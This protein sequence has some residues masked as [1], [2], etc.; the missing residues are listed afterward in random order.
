[1]SKTKNRIEIILQIISAFLVAIII[2][3]CFQTNQVNLSDV[4]SPKKAY[5]NIADYQKDRWCTIRKEVFG[6][7]STNM[8]DRDIA[9]NEVIAENKYFNWADTSSLDITP[10]N[11]TTQSIDGTEVNWSNFKDEATSITDLDIESYDYSDSYENAVTGENVQVNNNMTYYVANVKTAEEFRWILFQASKLNTYS[12]KINIEKDI[13]LNGGNSKIWKSISLSGNRYVYI[14]GN[15]H[16]IYNFR[17]A[18]RDYT[19]GKGLLGVI[20]T[21]LIIKNLNFESALNITTSVNSAILIGEIDDTISKGVYLDNIKFDKIFLQ[22]SSTNAGALIGRTNG[23]KNKSVF[24]KNCSERN[25]YVCGTEHIGGLTGC[26]LNT[27]TYAVKYNAA[28][29]N[30]PE[31]F[32]GSAIYPEMIDSCYAVDSEVFSTG[33]D[34][35][36]FISCGGKIIVRNCFTNNTIYANIYTGVFIGREVSAQCG[37]VGLYD[38]SGNTSINSYFENCYTSGIIEGANGIGG[39]IGYLNPT[40]RTKSAVFKNCYSTSMVGM[41][42]AGNNVGGFIGYD[43]TPSTSDIA[44]KIDGEIKNFKGVVIINSYAAGEVGDIVTNT[45]NTENNKSTIGGFIGSYTNNP[46]N[47][48]N[49]YYDKQTTGMRERGIGYIP[50]NSTGQHPGLTGTYTVGSNLEGGTPGLTGKTGNIVDL[51]DSSVWST[52]DGIYPQ[53][54]V[55]EN[56]SNWSSEEMELVKCYSQA[57][58]STVFLEHWDHIMTS[59]NQTYNIQ[60]DELFTPTAKAE[61]NNY[62]YDT[63]RD[64]TLK[65]EFSSNENSEHTYNNI[66]W[67]VDNEMNQSRNFVEDFSIDYDN[68]TVTGE[69]QYNADVL[70]ILNPGKDTDNINPELLELMQSL[71]ETK[72]IYKCYEFAPGKSWIKVEVKSNDGNIT[73]M[74][75]LR[76]LPMAYLDAGNYAE[77]SIDADGNNHIVYKSSDGTEY[78]YNGENYKH[79]IDTL[80]TNTSRENLGNGT[81]YQSQEVSKSNSTKFAMWGRYPANE[82]KLDNTSRFDGLYNQ[83]MI[84]NATEGMT[85]VEVYKLDVEYIEKRSESGQVTQIP[86]IN[87][88]NA[89][90]ITEENLDNEKWTGMVNFGLD[91]AGWYELRYYWRLNDGR[92][93]SDSKIVVIK[94]STYTANIK[95]QILNKDVQTDPEIMPDI[96]D[97]TNNPENLV[98]DGEAVDTSIDQNETIIRTKEISGFA[99]DEVLMGWK[100]DGNYK[101]VDVKI[102]VSQ[103]GTNWIPLVLQLENPENPYDFINAKYT[104]YYQ[105]YKMIQNP[106]TKEYYLV[107]TD[108]PKEISTTIT[109]MQLGDNPDYAKYI[110]LS[111][112]IKEDDDSIRSVNSDVRVSATF[113]PMDTHVK[114]E[115]FV[116]KENVFSGDEVT[117]TVIM[118]P[119]YYKDAFDINAE[120]IIPL[121]TEY[122]P[123][124][125]EIGEYIENTNTYIPDDENTSQNFENNTLTWHYDKMEY[126]KKYYAKFK[127]KVTGVVDKDKEDFIK[128]DNV[129]N[130]TYRKSEFGKP[131]NGE[132]SEAATFIII[133]E[134]RVYLIIEKNVTTANAPI[135]KFKMNAQIEK[136]GDDLQ[137]YKWYV[138][139]EKENENISDVEITQNQIAMLVGRTEGE[140][141]LD[142]ASFKIK[143]DLTNMPANYYFSSI[144][145]SGEGILE[146]GK[147]QKVIVSNYYKAPTEQINVFIEKKDL[148]SQEYVSLAQMKLQKQSDNEEYV[149]YLIWQTTQSHKTVPLETGKY[150]IIEEVAPTDYQL[151]ETP[152]EFEIVKNESGNLIVKDAEGSILEDKRITFYNERI[153]YNYTVEYYYDNIKDEDKTET[154]RGIH[155]SSIDAYTDKVIPG[156]ELDKTESFPLTVTDNESKNVIKVFYKKRNDLSY[157]VRYREEG[158]EDT[159]ADLATALTIGEQTFGDRVTVNAIAIDGYEKVE[160]TSAE[161]EITAGTNEYIFYYRKRNDLSYTVRYREEGAEDTE[162]DLAT[163]LTVGEQTFGDKVTVNAIAIDG[164]EKVDPTSADIEITTGTN[165]HI[166]YYTKRN[167]LSYTVNY[168]DKIT[169]E[170]IHDSKVQDRQ[171]YNDEIISEDEKIEIDGYVFDSS[172]KEKIQIGIEDNIINLYYRKRNDLSYK[173]NY[174]ESGTGKTLHNAKIQNDQEFKKVINANDEIIEIYGYNFDR[175]DKESI[176]I[177]TGEN[178]INLYYSKKDAKVIVHHYAENSITK[179]SEDVEINN[180]MFDKY[181]TQAATDIDNKYELVEVPS[182]AKGEMN[183]EKIEVIYYYKV[184]T[185]TVKIKYIDLDNNNEIAN[186][187]TISGKVDTNYETTSKEIDNYQLVKDSKNTTGKYTVEPI[188]VIYYYLPK[189]KV[190]V[191]YIDKNYNNILETVTINGLLGDEYTTIAKNIERYCLIELPEKTEGTMTR[192]D[193]IVNYY[194]VHVSAGVIEKHIDIATGEILESTVHEGNEGDSY[195][196]GSKQFEGYILDENS[197][198]DNNKGKMKQDVIEVIYYYK[199]PT[200]VV[201]KYIDKITEKEIETQETKTGFENDEYKTEEKEIADYKLFEKPRNAEGIMTKKEIEVIYYYTH[202]SAGVVENHIDVNTGKKLVDEI[203]HEG[204]EGDD[205]ITKEKSFE[206]YDLVEEKYTENSKGKMVIGKIEVNYYY[207][208]QTSIVVKYIDKFTGEEISAKQI[209]EGHEGEDYTTEAKEINNYELIS[210]PANKKG[211]MKANENIEVIYKYARKAVVISNYKEKET[212]AILVDKEVIEGY[213]G[214]KYETQEKELQYYVLEETPENAEG[215]MNVKVTRNKNGEDI[216]DNTTY[217]DY[218]YRKKIFNLK[219]EEQVENIKINGNKHTVSGKL[220]KTEINKAEIKNAN[221]EVSYKIIVTNNGELA[222]KGVVVENIPTGMIMKEENNPGWKISDKTATIETGELKPGET[223]EYTINLIWQN[224]EQNFGTVENIVEVKMLENEA[225]FAEINLKDNKDKATT[226][227][228]IG[229]GKT[230]YAVITGAIIM[231]LIAVVGVIYKKYRR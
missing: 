45:E 193:I 79:D 159:E 113:V 160:P 143:E 15:G 91:D 29:P 129:V 200:K 87:Y 212:G 101:L 21:G 213:Q 189:T 89:I 127:V 59:D 10:W 209:V 216:V 67:S 88:D 131:V 197:L 3:Q 205:Y 194:Y 8:M 37:E 123:D 227:I 142:G 207:S 128:V 146:P 226:I 119:D 158:A 86:R 210:E 148:D 55:F 151:N 188:E 92:Y 81:N 43:C 11:G 153:K 156:Y 20:T 196:I 48:I 174:I 217:V 152:F 78:E 118:Q 84:G 219:I 206:G 223:K 107:E 42:Y 76:L 30:T 77:I 28:F 1:M 110:Y 144:T 203:I 191:N 108:T 141:N 50:T 178:I 12:I 231:V 170:E 34:S 94:G 208:K 31:A 2:V 155:R 122:I 149:D 72:D 182:N 164:Y 51:N 167:D 175:F 62:V 85:K 66:T 7:T 222:G 56:A 112:D 13:D 161:M 17:N 61:E 65:F 201:V 120:D 225:G 25:S 32:L 38:D 68:A 180:K 228:S 104:Y 18:V 169:K 126:G 60:T 100:N 179:L 58:V 139:Y 105:D 230:Y 5:T 57:S 26:Q 190:I 171:K 111:F 116:D 117:Y 202:I 63:I 184:K 70:T 46:T 150:R 165:E 163:A 140:N 130:F 121:N 69:S 138:D 41:E 4:K 145:N 136:D 109:P 195:E 177:G 6:S 218:L 102:E 74:R 23:A 99:G 220:G 181:E 125:F 173:V 183:V 133:Q 185:S 75:K 83:K 166:F 9:Q 64:I 98:F 71:G 134:E 27:G 215:T 162:A 124:S 103:D 187:E 221:V 14:E 224:Q 168:L 132:P 49:C 147:V 154:L 44:L 114:A 204:C 24:I 106:S 54:S 192:Q 39:F 157:T 73:G 172:E 16:T 229:T 22:S 35:G 214:D 52:H 36:G 82:N 115:K 40:S 93:L 137:Q 176:T 33:G 97:K 186:Q 80:Y 53:L 90:R 19:T 199:Y 135:A 198:P 95:N 47:I 211:Q 96:K